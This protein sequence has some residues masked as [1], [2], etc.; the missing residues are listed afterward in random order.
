MLVITNGIFFS[1]FVIY[2]YNFGHRVVYSYKFGH[3]LVYSYQLVMLWS[4]YT[5]LVMLWSIHTSLFMGLFIHTSLAMFWS[6]HISLVG[7]LVR[8]LVGFY[9]ISTFVGHLTQNPFLY[10][11]SVLFQTIQISM[12]TQFDRQKHFC[13]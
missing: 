2:S 12:S 4:I 11:Y 13:F 10:K 5:S 8:S 1:H 3:V 7:S 9:G 6:I